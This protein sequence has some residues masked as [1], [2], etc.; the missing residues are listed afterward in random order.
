MHPFVSNVRVFA[1]WITDGLD[2]QNRW[3]AFQ[4]SFLSSQ[5]VEP[6]RVGTLGWI[7]PAIADFSCLQP[8]DCH[9][10]PFTPIIIYAPGTGKPT[11]PIRKCLS[12]S[13]TLAQNL[14]NN[15]QLPN[16]YFIYQAVSN[17]IRIVRITKGKTLSM[18]NN[19][20]TFYRVIYS[21][22]KKIWP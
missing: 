7:I 13:I 6:T 3:S 16:I 15:N 10:R 8:F 14:W 12:S 1:R 18:F 19:S 4:G 20:R 22:P 17:K 21:C 5:F 2:A 11:H 9:P